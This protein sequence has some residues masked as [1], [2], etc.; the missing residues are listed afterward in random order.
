MSAPVRPDCVRCGRPVATEHYELFERMHYVCFHYEFEHGDLDVDEECGAGGC[1]SRTRAYV[2]ATPRSIEPGQLV[3]LTG[4]FF[5]ERSGRAMI[6]LPNGAKT[7]VDFGA[8]VADAGS[9][10]FVR[11]SDGSGET[12]W[13]T[14]CDWHVD[15]SN[16]VEAE[17]LYRGH[18]LR[19]HRADGGDRP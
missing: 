13:C 2:A 11:Q 3:R 12:A 14:A 6:R 4:T 15:A 1:P 18:W 16:R 7:T 19:S 8:L 9:V 17:E 10:H 5:E